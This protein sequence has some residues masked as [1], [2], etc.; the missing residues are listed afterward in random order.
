MSSYTIATP[1]LYYTLISYLYVSVSNILSAVTKHIT[2]KKF[3]YFNGRA[4]R[5]K[6]FWL[7]INSNNKSDGIS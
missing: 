5:K 6:V 1:Y 7:V 4:L 2:L 3:G